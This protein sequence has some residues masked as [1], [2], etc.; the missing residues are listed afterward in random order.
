METAVHAAKPV[1][2]RAQPWQKK[3]MP[4]RILVIRLQATGD[5]VIT[6]PYLQ[7]L[8]NHLPA[9]TRIDLLTRVETAP[10]PRSLHLFDHIYTIAGER[11][12]KKQL[13]FAALLVPRLCLQ[14]YDMVID[15]QNTLISRTITQCIRP[16]AWSLFDKQAPLPAGE[17]YRLTIEAAGLGRNDMNT[18]YRLKEPRKAIQLLFDAGWK[19]K[20]PLVILN[21]AGAFATRNWDMAHYTTFARLWLNRFP[22]TRFLVL[23]TGVIAEKAA[24]LQNQLGDRLINFTQKTNPAEAFA[25]I[26]HA[27]LV[28][29]EDSGLM[30]MA[31]VS[32]VPTMAL[33]GST[34]SDW[35]RP[36]GAHTAFFDSSD[37]PCGNCMLA[38]CR[39][40]DNRCLTRYTPAMVFRTALSLLK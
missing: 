7:Y 31:W 39:W 29:S 35:A 33:F 9:G 16:R 13:F 36:L 21:P 11:N 6:L 25:L 40:G 8:R 17:R 26:R 2:I 30:H 20:E 23:G 18:H 3:E 4:R 27:T 32:G 38:T 37:L 15:L 1:N 24:L 28:L 5:V 10:I 14:R 22:H 19:E 12:F 34:R